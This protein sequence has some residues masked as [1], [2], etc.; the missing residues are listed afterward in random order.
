MKHFFLLFLIT[1]VFTS[2]GEKSYNY[3]VGKINTNQFVLDKGIDSIK[4]NWQ[5]LLN[6]NKIKGSLSR[7]EIKKDVDEV[8][9]KE[10]YILIGYSQNDSIKV[11]SL[12]KKKNKNFYFYKDPYRIVICHGCNNSFPKYQFDKWGWS[13]DSKEIRVGCKKTETIKF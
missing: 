13:C 5:L 6:T 8:N 10:Y 9:K 11:A 1:T 4:T 2:C 12:L 7:F 3:S